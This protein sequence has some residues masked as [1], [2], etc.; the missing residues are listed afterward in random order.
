MLPSTYVTLAALPLTANGKIDRKALPAPESVAQAAPSALPQN[1]LEEKIARIWRAALGL[2]QVGVDDRFFDVGGDSLQLLT[3]HGE[4]EKTLAPGIT[5]VDLFQ[6][7]TVRELAAHLNQRTNQSA[8]AAAQESGRKQ[9][10]SWARFKPAR[11]KAK[12]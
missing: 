11:Q 5:V 7:S 6:Y 12:R 9:S 3:V 8:M 1:E 10:Q 2:K 4:I